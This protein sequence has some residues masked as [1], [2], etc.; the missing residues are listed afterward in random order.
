MKNIKDIIIGI[1]AVVG[2][3]AIVT[4]FTNETSDPQY[5]ESHVWEGLISQGESSAA[6]RLYMYNKVTGEVRKYN[7]IYPSFKGISARD[8]ARA[9][10]VTE[11][12]ENID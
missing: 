3:A 4:G 6:G 9:Y 7:R 10:I 8:E 2:F 5:P 1:F 11:N 12:I